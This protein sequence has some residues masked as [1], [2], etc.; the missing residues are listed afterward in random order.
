MVLLY[1]V[2]KAPHRGFLSSSIQDDFLL[3]CI[4]QYLLSYFCCQFRRMVF[5]TSLYPAISLS[6]RFFGVVFSFANCPILVLVVI[7]GLSNLG[8]KLPLTRGLRFVKSQVEDHCPNIHFVL[9][10]VRLLSHSRRS[11]FP[12]LFTCV[13]AFR[14]SSGHPVRTVDV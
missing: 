14:P 1:K 3:T 8:L 12:S 7:M 2:K 9:H 5:I 10:S 6:S 4:C 11:S 13:P